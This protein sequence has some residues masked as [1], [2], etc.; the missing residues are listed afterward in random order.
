AA[1]G[2]G[3]MPDDEMEIRDR[4]GDQRSHPDHCEAAD[5]EVV[6]DHAAGPD[7]GPL[8]HQRGQGMLV[9]LGRPELLQVWRRGPRE[10]IVGEDGPGADHH[11]VLDRHG[12]ADVYEGIDLDAVPDAHVVCDVGLLTDDALLADPRRAPDVDVV[13]DRRAGADLH[14]LLDD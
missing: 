14:S 4:S 1:D 12:R 3:W 9:G 13:P 10:A 5:R 8:A 11:A 7:R 6:A 2:P